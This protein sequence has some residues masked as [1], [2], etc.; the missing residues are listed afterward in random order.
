MSSEEPGQSRL[1]N[2][3]LRDQKG[4]GDGKNLPLNFEE[5]KE[6]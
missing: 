1:S 6:S 3:W 5:L 4:Y 2:A